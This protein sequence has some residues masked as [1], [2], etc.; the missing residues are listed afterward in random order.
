[1]IFAVFDVQDTASRGKRVYNLQFYA[2]MVKIY[3][4]LLEKVT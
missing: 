4:D 2:F 3:N 1:M